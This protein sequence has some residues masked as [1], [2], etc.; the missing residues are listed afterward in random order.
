MNAAV[1]RPCRR[2]AGVVVSLVAL[3]VPLAACSSAGGRSDKT[4]QAVLA[5]AKEAL[6]ETS[7]VTLSLTT[8]KLPDKVD[9]V[10]EA[11]GVATHAPAFA[12]DLTVL[13]NGL[14]VDVPVVS[15]DGKV[16]AKLPFTLAFA[17]VNPADYGAP[18]PAQLMVPD[19]GLSTWLADATGIEEGGRARDG[20]LVLSSYT[21]SLPGEVVDASIPSADADADFPVTFQIDEDGRLRSVKISGPFYG[22]KGTVDYTVSVDDYG[23][24]TDIKKP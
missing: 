21:G 9:G 11:T 5:A 24:D 10:L 16:Y 14:N 13:V 17:E 18:D 20:E 22:S 19:T 7:G 12:G 3:M 8:E 6:D 15:V 1:R 23:T 2:R 4:P